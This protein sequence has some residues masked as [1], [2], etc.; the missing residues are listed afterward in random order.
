MSHR[1]E[2]FGE[3]ADYSL[4]AAIPAR[5][6]TFSER[7]DLS[8][9]HGLSPLR[10][11][12]SEASVPRRTIET[13][14]IVKRENQVSF[15]NKCCLKGI[16]Y[17][18]PSPVYTYSDEPSSVEIARWEGVRLYKC[19]RIRL[20]MTGAPMTRTKA[21]KPTKS[22]S[23]LEAAIKSELRGVDRWF[24]D[25]GVTVCPMGRAGKLFSRRT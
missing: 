7:R 5:R 24:P 21:R 15:R 2:L 6:N 18:C 10:K 17:S 19:F 9:L 3:I 22:A 23:E 12:Q 20:S 13:K 16:D 25:A 4:R 11:Q 8:D 1:D 14:K